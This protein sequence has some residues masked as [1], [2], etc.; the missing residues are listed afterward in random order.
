MVDEISGIK[1]LS[2]EYFIISIYMLIRH[3]GG[4]YVLDDAIKKQFENLCITL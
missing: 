1:E 3:L 2:V 4:Y